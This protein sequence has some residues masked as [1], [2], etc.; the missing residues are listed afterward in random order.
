MMRTSLPPALTRL[1]LA[2]L[3]FVPGAIPFA[4]AQD[5]PSRPLTL[6]VGFP[7]GGADDAVARLMAPRLAEKLGQSVNVENVGG[8]SGLTAGARVAKAAPD[9][10]EMMLGS[11]SI[12]AASQS[13]FKNPPFKSETDFSPVALLLE[14]PFIVI[15]R[16]DFSAA[17][18]QAFIA[19]AKSASAPVRYGSAGTGSATHLACE[20]FAQAAGIKAQHVPFNGGAPAMQAL[21]AGEIDYQCPIIT[22]PV[23]KLKSGEVNG[24]AVL[25]RERSSA[26]PGVASAQEQG[27]ANF[28]AT[29]WFALFLPAKSPPDIVRKLN[30]AA[31]AALDDPALQKS[32]A[33]I[34]GSVVARDRRSP[35]HLQTFL[36]AE[37]E[38]WSS[39]VTAAGISLD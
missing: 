17:N 8:R 34:G 12:H 3:L 25:S 13:V 37:I 33:E 39:V 1:T 22:L 36:K 6:V 2:F 30:A 11:S 38:K 35:D 31:V 24:I 32:I 15:A 23:G 5:W 26:L 19:A 9:G 27:L 7:A 16:K 10:Y 28:T 4:S 21:L 18:L 20:R 29:T 14:Q